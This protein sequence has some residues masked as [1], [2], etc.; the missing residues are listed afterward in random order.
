MPPSIDTNDEQA[1]LDVGDVVWVKPPSARCTTQWR[2]GVVTKVNTSKNVEVDGV[3]RHIGD[4][5]KIARITEG[6]DS[7]LDVVSDDSD[8]HE[9]RYPARE[10]RSPT[11][12]RDYCM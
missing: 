4:I 3:P 5:R 2:K 1:S 6:Q 9:R 8:A 12:A 11:W 10:R 7:F